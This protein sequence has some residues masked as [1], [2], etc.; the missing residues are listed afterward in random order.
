MNRS[1]MPLKTRLPLCA[2]VVVPLALA[3]SGC[4][5]SLSGS[6][7]RQDATGVRGEP[8]QSAMSPPYLTDVDQSGTRAVAL[9]FGEG[10]PRTQSGSQ[11]KRVEIVPTPAPDRQPG[12]SKSKRPEIVP[13]PAGVPA[14]E[15]VPEAKMALRDTEVESEPAEA[16][17]PAAVPLLDGADGPEDFRSW[18]IPDVTLFVTGQQHGYIEPCGCTGLDRQKG[19]LARRFTFMRELREQGWTLLPVDAG[20]QV[21]RFGRQAEVK[22]QQTV[23]ALKSMD[24]QAIGFGPDDIRLGVGELLAVAAGDT[25]DDT[26]YVSANVVLIDPSLMPQSKVVEKN[27]RKIGITSVLDTDA[28]EV[29][30]N[31]EILIEPKVDSTRKALAEMEAAGADFKVLMCFGKE[32]AAQQIVQDVP[33]FDLLVVAGGYGEPTYRPES[34]EGSSTKMIVTG[35]KAMY[36]GLVGLYDDQPFKYARLSLDHQFSDAPEMRQLMKEYQDQLRDIGLQG[37]G[38]LPPIP[39]SSRHEFV[40]SEACGECHTTAY[41]IWQSTP[42]AEATEHIVR[43]PRERG[44]IA[45][46]FDPEC[47]SCHVT[48]WNAQEFYPYASGYLSLEQS[49]HLTGA[50]CE[51]CHGPGA[52]HVAAE[53]GTGVDD[54]LR[55]QLRQAMRLPLENAREKCMSCHDLDNSPDFHEEDAFED[56]YWPE[57]EHYGMD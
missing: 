32:D 21:R 54:E 5:P 55:E 25:P 27:G 2:A 51:N 47:I 29:T 20:N 22:L 14:V 30:P 33:G 52:E 15:G 17:D 1:K 24:Y 3:A 48:G 45:R 7:D 34:I 36:V 43:P 56:V 44:D 38:L 4:S 6:A 16:T 9:R 49:E 39:H 11:P 37:L 10:D 50:G 13:T 46:H 41:D 53:A 40:G 31:S 28:V 23:K 57:V 8:G 12:T 26:M 19:G 18:E 42:H 35:N